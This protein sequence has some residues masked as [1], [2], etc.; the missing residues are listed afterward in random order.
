M[1]RKHFHH[2]HARHSSANL[3]HDIK[4][5]LV[6]KVGD[7]SSW[8]YAPH[9]NWYSYAVPRSIELRPLDENKD[10]MISHPLDI[11]MAVKDLY[12]FKG[13][14]LPLYERRPSLHDWLAM[15][16]PD[17]HNIAYQTAHTHDLF[18]MTD[19]YAFFYFPDEA[20]YIIRQHKEIINAATRLYCLASS[21]VRRAEQ[22]LDDLAAVEEEAFTLLKGRG[23][24]KD[25]DAIEGRDKIL[26]RILR[27]QEESE[28]FETEA[29]RSLELLTLR[30]V[31][32]YQDTTTL[33]QLM[34]KELEI[35][36]LLRLFD[37]IM[38]NVREKRHNL[39]AVFSRVEAEE[40][41]DRN[42]RFATVSGAGIL[43][44]TAIGLD[45]FLTDVANALAETPMHLPL[46]PLTRVVVTTVVIV[47]LAIFMY[48]KYLRPLHHRS[49]KR[50]QAY[51]EAAF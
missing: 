12:E 14:I 25:K 1:T 33:M 10:A 5:T 51:I 28:R 31:C 26:A 50:R 30:V 8:I 43:I 46:S 21:M 11:A 15:R 13:F 39:T 32:L 48:F 22:E 36:G 3:T 37:E 4:T 34:S 19:H 44:L 40:N 9:L 2:Y 38:R 27:R 42:E 45:A 18:Y 29:R 7:D 17:S 49:K 20:Y 35:D 24:L 47:L 16:T 41:N 23:R 6:N